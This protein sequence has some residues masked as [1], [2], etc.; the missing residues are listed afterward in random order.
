[1]QQEET[2][3]PTAVILLCSGQSLSWSGIENAFGGSGQEIV[4]S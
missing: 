4:Y 2:V 1:M 3:W